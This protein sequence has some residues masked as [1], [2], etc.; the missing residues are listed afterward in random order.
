MEDG[1][2]AD[3]KRVARPQKNVENQWRKKYTPGHIHG[4]I[5]KGITMSTRSALNIWVRVSTIVLSNLALRHC[6]RHVDA[7]PALRSI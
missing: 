7:D 2:N 5:R 4:V 3:A 1:K 6:L